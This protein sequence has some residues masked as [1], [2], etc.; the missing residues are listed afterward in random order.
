M[1]DNY[2]SAICNVFVSSP[3]AW[4]DR[5]LYSSDHAELG[6]RESNDLRGLLQLFQ[7][8]WLCP[9]TFTKCWPQKNLDCIEWWTKTLS[10]TKLPPRPL[11]SSEILDTWGI[12]WQVTT[13]ARV[14]CFDFKMQ[15]GPWSMGPYSSR[16]RW[17]L[18]TA[19]KL[20][21]QVG[22]C[23]FI[24]FFIQFLIFEFHL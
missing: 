15:R 22:E 16:R 4:T 3:E 6:T 23:H 8:G 17:G 1:L 7:I 14:S 18:A 5:V 13:R 21:W 10:L 11:K 19:M 20:R 2:N 12:G 24:V 9:L